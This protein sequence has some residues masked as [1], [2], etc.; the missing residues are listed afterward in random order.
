MHGMHGVETRGCVHGKTCKPTVDILSY[1][2]DVRKKH[3]S[4]V[5]AITGKSKIDSLP[6]CGNSHGV[7]V[8][9]A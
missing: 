5:V 9:Y 4:V 2:S 6:R 8:E 7:A 3:S 1:L